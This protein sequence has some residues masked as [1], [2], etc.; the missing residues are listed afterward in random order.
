MLGEV[1]RKIV[2]G[3]FPYEYELLLGFLV[4]EAVVLHIDG[5]CLLLSNS[6]VGKVHGCNIVQ[7]YW[8]FSLRPC[9]LV[10]QA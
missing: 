7:H 8:D 6:V 5:M 4:V 1:V 3:T 10:L 9:I 2:D